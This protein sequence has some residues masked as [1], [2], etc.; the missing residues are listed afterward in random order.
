MKVKAL[1]NREFSRQEDWSGLSFPSPK[2]LPNPGIEPRSSILQ[3]DSLLTEPP[4]NLG[5]M[6]PV[7][8]CGGVLTEATSGKHA[9]VKPTLVSLYLQLPLS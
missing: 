1:L 2:G 6:L 4:R 3:A 5:L 7:S 9:S 8:Q